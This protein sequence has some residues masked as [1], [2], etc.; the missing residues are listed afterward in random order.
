LQLCVLGAVLVHSFAAIRFE[1]AL[2]IVG[3]YLLSYW[4]TGL[5]HSYIGERKPALVGEPLLR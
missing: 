3:S 5:L 4:F 2:V 1:G